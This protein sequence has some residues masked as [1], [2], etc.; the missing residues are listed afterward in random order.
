[1]LRSSVTGNGG[2]GIAATKPGRGLAPAHLE[3][4]RRQPGHA[5]PR[6]SAPS[7]PTATPRSSNSTISG[8]GGGFVGGIE[9]HGA[10]EV[11]FSTIADNQ[12][13]GGGGHASGGIDVDERGLGQ[14]RRRD[15]V[16]AT[17]RGSSSRTAT[18]PWT[19]TCARAWRTGTCADWTVRPEPSLAG[20][21]PQLAP[22]ASNGGP[23][24][25]RGLYPGEPGDRRGRRLRP[26]SHRPARRLA[27][28]RRL[29]HRRLRGVGAA[30][31]CRPAER[32]GAAV[33][34]QEEEEVQAEEEGDEPRTPRASKRGKCKSKPKRRAAPS[35]RRV[36]GRSVGGRAI[37][38]VRVG[39]PAAERVALAVGVIHGDERAG[40]AITRELR[41]L[42]S[43]IDAQVWV[44]DSLNPDGA[45]AR[46]PP[47][48]PRRRPQPQLPAPLA[49][50][51][52]AVERLLPWAPP[53]LGARDARRHGLHPRDRP[54][55]LRLVPPAV[56]RGA[57]LS[58]PARRSRPAT[59][60]WRRWARAA[61]AGGCRGPR[62]A[63]SG[64]RLGADAFV[65]E[66]ARRR[67]QRRG[68]PPPRPRC[69]ATRG[70]RLRWA[71]RD[72]RRWP[73]AGRARR[74]QRGRRDAP[75]AA[76]P[77]R[78]RPPRGAPS[79]ASPSA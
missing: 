31:A 16:A 32:A 48:R 75:A 1:M 9:A 63:G 42:G 2:G 39:D 70:G 45:R 49:R 60:S 65:V 3:H 58:R 72:G 11:T 44:I 37:R 33:E 53:G 55:H 29:R 71:G 73:G 15:P 4:G 40:L 18:S 76:R 10:L 36:I 62:S 54:R 79:R 66:L 26:G 74:R 6:R 19:P 12:A 56:G 64:R 43:A 21:D 20:T 61:A 17:R 35:E 59:R 13:V 51:R 78:R 22:L 5:S 27:P 50:R 25:T 14:P 23:T 77:T 69:A 41:A 8:N 28:G 34:A 38:A 7:T 68:G 47:Q 67:H 52:P 57:R 24:Q 46:T 30:A